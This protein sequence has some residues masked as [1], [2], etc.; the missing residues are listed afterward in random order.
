[1]RSGFRLDNEADQRIDES[2]GVGDAGNVAGHLQGLDGIRFGRSG[3]PSESQCERDA[4]P[5][6]GADGVDVKFA[7]TGKVMGEYGEAG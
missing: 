2:A 5:D 4:Q 3:E 6:E 1:M 7:M